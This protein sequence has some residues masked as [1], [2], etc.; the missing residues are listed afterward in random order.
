ML[1]RKRDRFERLSAY[2]NRKA[3]AFIAAEFTLSVIEQ[4]LRIFHAGA[5]SVGTARL[6]TKLREAQ[7]FFDGGFQGGFTNGVT[8]AN[9]HTRWTRSLGTEMMMQM[10]MV[11]N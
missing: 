4:R 5:A 2:Q 3:E 6:R 10:R 8:D 11:V 9:V 1:A 7:A